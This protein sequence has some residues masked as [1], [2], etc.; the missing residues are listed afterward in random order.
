MHR[1]ASSLVP[2][3]KVEAFVFEVVQRY[4]L[5]SLSCNMDNI[6]PKVVDSVYICAIFQQ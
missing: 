5:V 1:G 6:N 3:S 4:G 2:T